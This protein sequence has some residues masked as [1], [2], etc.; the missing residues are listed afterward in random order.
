M[1]WI[2]DRCK[3]PDPGLIGSDGK[4]LI[5]ITISISSR[6]LTRKDREFV[7]NQ[8]ICEACFNHMNKAWDE[9]IGEALKA[10]A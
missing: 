9:P 4:A 8:E 10:E 2:C 6:I 3:R 7:E 1:A 5:K